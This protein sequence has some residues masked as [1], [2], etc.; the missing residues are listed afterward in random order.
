MDKGAQ[1][2]DFVIVGGGT[3]GCVLARRL[4]DDPSVRVLLLEAGGTGGLKDPLDWPSAWGSE[5]DWAYRTEPQSGLDG[6]V[7]PQPRGKGLG[8]SSIINVMVHIRAHQSSYDAWARAGAT[9]W[10]AT[11]LLPYFKRTETAAGMDPK[12]RGQD[13]PMIVGPTPPAVPGS[14]FAA[15]YDAFRNAGF[16]DTVD[17]NGEVIEGLARTELNIV[18]GIRQTA[19]DAYVRPVL[20][21][22]NLTVVTGAFAR[23]L[24]ISKDRC[25]GVEYAVDDRVVTA[26]ASRDVVL[27]AGTVGS[28]QLLLLSGLGPA[29]QLREVGVEVVHDLPGV[30][31]N[32]QDHPFA[33]ISFSAPGPLDLG[34]PPDQAHL[35]TRSTPDADPDLQLM[36]VNLPLPMRDPAASSEPWGSSDWT[37]RDVNGYSVIYS[38]V[39]PISRGTLRLS[40]GDPMGA[41]LIDPE[42]YSDPSDLHRMVTAFRLA[43]ELGNSPVLDEFR[44][45]ELA[46]GAGAVDDQSVRAHVKRVTGSFFHL[47][48]T[49]AM[50]T[51]ELAVVDPGLRV[52]GIEGLV[53][54][55]A[56]V[57]PS[58]VAANTNGTV[59]AIAERAAD[60]LTSTP[61]I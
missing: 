41:P 23:R 54:A 22:V 3:A 6:V 10:D 31:R 20:D 50:G 56:S 34:V 38:L 26:R 28:A 7:V 15:T 19:A 47:T 8:G 29:D 11:T 59:M 58:I 16:K 17:G 42:F 43:R 1:S 55:D 5:F 60:L 12:W 36:F 33:H 35:V 25:E 13:G 21:R 4:S 51:D 45:A 2:F 52:R 27:S 24:L 49:C 18:D 44:V 46:P 30:G 61:R 40:G 53:V 39:Q 57:M 9:G 48:G 32:L 14:F 37:V